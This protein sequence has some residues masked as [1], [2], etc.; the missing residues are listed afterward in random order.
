MAF[1]SKQAV[2][3]NAPGRRPARRW[4]ASGAGKVLEPIEATVVMDRSAAVDAMTEVV[5]SLAPANR[6][7]AP[8]SPW[9][10]SRRHGTQSRSRCIATTSIFAR[11]ATSSCVNCG[12]GRATGRWARSARGLRS[13]LDTGRTHKTPARGP[14]RRARSAG[15]TDTP[16]EPTGHRFVV[17][18][19]ARLQRR[20]ELTS[21]SQSTRMRMTTPPITSPTARSVRGESRW[22]LWHSMQAS[23]TARSAYTAA[24]YRSPPSSSSP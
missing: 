12:S 13:R 21:R 22:L 20:V 14:D 15:R 3:R 4:S 23:A 10:V 7:R 11:A 1:R 24:K 2:R 18:S 5:P 16:Q 17:T 9:P 6:R 8:D 19:G